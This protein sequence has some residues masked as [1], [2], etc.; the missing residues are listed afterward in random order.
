MKTP[1]PPLHLEIGKEYRTRNGQKAIVDEAGHPDRYYV[2]RV[3]V[4][5]LLWVIVGWHA[6]GRWMLDCENDCDIIGN[7]H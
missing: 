5:G 6:D 3:H 4:S 1:T 7:L 2:G